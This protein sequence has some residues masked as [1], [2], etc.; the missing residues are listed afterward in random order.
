M[1]SSELDLSVVSSVAG[2]RLNNS[3]A[4]HR[5]A[6]KPR[7]Q[8]PLTQYQPYVS[9]TALSQVRGHSPTLSLLCV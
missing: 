2:F 9:A 7:G 8:R 3:A 1:S 6:V 4:L 5:R